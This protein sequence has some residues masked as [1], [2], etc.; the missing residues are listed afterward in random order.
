MKEK[1]LSSVRRILTQD[2]FSVKIYNN[3]EPTITSKQW[4]KKIYRLFLLSRIY[5]L[6][7][8][9]FQFDPKV[10]CCLTCSTS[11]IWLFKLGTFWRFCCF[12]ESFKLTKKAENPKEHSLFSN[13]NSKCKKIKFECVT[14]SSEIKIWKKK[15]NSCKKTKLF[16]LP[17]IIFLLSQDKLSLSALKGSWNLN[18]RNRQAWLSDEVTKFRFSNC[19][20]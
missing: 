17:N 12:K 9:I 3:L 19:F 14:N 10:F 2:F 13:E 11:V 4:I 20:L 8:R 16:L 5:C 1:Y 15:K 7:S 6:V 18:F